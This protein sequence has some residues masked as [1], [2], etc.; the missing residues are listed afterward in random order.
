MFVVVASGTLGCFAIANLGKYDL[1]EEP[2]AGEGG[3]DGGGESDAPP[4]G[5][6]VDPTRGASVG[7]TMRDMGVHLNQLIEFRLIDNQNTIQMRG[8]VLPLDKLGTQSITLNV[9]NSV[10]LENRPYRLD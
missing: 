3:T 6:V 1:G 5:G 9:P 4:A 7:F 2:L 10:P 8:V